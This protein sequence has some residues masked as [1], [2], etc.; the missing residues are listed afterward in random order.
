M[1]IGGHHG[2]AAFVFHPEF[3]PIVVLE[4]PDKLVAEEALKDVYISNSCYTSCRAR[5]F[6]CFTRPF[7]HFLFLLI[8]DDICK[9]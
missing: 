4:L 3:K 5:D 7:G 6:F 2:E 8:N 1:L 9:Y